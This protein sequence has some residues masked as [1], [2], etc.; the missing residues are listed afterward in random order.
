MKWSIK[1]VLFEYFISRMA[2]NYT[3]VQVYLILL[4]EDITGSIKFL[5]LIFM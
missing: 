2:G 3:I 5:S 4:N 1:I